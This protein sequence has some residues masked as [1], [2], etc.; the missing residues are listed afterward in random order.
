MR[1]QTSGASASSVAFDARLGLLPSG[2]NKQMVFQ[3]NRGEMTVTFLV[4]KIQT[5]NSLRLFK[6]QI[7]KVST[8]FSFIVL[9]L[10]MA[11]SCLVSNRAGD[12]RGIAIQ[13]TPSS[14]AKSMLTCMTTLHG[15]SS[16]VISG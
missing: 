16:Q 6:K 1:L 5:A 2:C 14:D 3:A 13:S 12:D 7:W 8:L 10:L 4:S 11:G 15:K 9:A